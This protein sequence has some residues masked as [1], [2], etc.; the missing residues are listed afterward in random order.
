MEQN[1]D[2][3][4][5][6]KERA[7]SFYN[8]N[9]LKIIFSIIIILLAIITLLMLN[10][11]KQKENI[12]ISD[13]YV[14][15]SMLLSNGKKEEAKNYYEEII[16]SKNKFYSILA[17][18]VILEKNLVSEKEKIFSYFQALEKIKTSNKNYDLIKFKKALYLIN[19]GNI[20]SGKKILKELIDKD[21][22]LKSLAQKLLEK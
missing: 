6:T 3:K 11:I 7:L 9:K 22:S 16:L 8:K 12:L 17:L 2:K 14:K 19:I 21:S 1:L 13:K 10:K 20:E 18:N 15:A 5:V 4:T